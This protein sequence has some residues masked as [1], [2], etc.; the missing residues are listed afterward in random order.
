MTQAQRAFVERVGRIAAAYMQ[1]YGILASLK[2][3]QAIL[4]SGWGTS[5]LA[6]KANALYGIKATST[7]KGRIY[8]TQTQEVF[9]GV[10]ATTINANFR[11][12]DSWEDSTADHSA[13][14][15]ANH[16]YSAVIGERDYKRACRAIH[17]AGYAT[18]PQYADKLIR[19]IEQ[20]NLT[21]YDIGV[22]TVMPPKTSG[23]KKMK[24]TLD[25]G[26]GERGNPYPPKPGFFEGTQM[27]KLAQFM[28]AE[29]ERRGFEVVNTRPRVSDN[30]PLATR[31]NMAATNGSVMFYSLHS[32]APASLT[33]T[34][35]TGSEVFISVR[36]T[37][38]RPLAEDLLRNVCAIMGHT[39]RG[40]KT[41]PSDTDPKSDF[42]GVLHAA[43]NGGLP[44]AMLMEFGFHT[45]PNDAAFLTDDTNLKRLAAGQAEI[46]AAYFKAT[47]GAQP[48]PPTTAPTQSIGFKVGD[49]VQFT[50]GGVYTSSNAHIPTHSRGASRCRV[51]QLAGGTRNP[52]HLVSEDSGRVHGWV[53]A[54]DVTAIGQAPAP[55]TEYTARVAAGTPFRAG[56]GAN[57][58]VTGT[59][60]NRGVFTIVA[61]QNGFGRL[62]SGAGWVCLAD[63][64]KI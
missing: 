22:A 14:L 48:T 58:P 31:G 32:N 11:A 17:A 39:S 33:Q 18:D 59:I 61:E 37:Q 34:T 53:V 3:A 30:P 63:I 28:T 8:N 1:F 21:K 12:Y 7:W 25:P 23:G 55:F 47:P 57:F 52:L 50:G 45:N 19:L 42:L 6:T 20:H 62:K 43:A 54:S 5:G 9:D 24:I 64:Q 4:E 60:P 44:C 38:F 16:R 10:N 56:A 15:I 13:F 46:I 36:G 40:V 51:T 49:V 41:K 29:L 35:V 27:W 2:L 26:H